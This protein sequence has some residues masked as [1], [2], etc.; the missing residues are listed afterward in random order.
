MAAS[1]FDEDKEDGA[2]D[3]E[4]EAEED[5]QGKPTSAE[6]VVLQALADRT[7]AWHKQMAEASLLGTA[8]SAA[9][10]QAHALSSPSRITVNTSKSP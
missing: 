2:S 4:E 5:L 8:R 9:T 3:S 1:K 6:G 7:D 10:M